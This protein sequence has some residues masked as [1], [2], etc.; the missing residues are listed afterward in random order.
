MIE[1][2]RSNILHI[3]LWIAQGLLALGFGLAGFMKSTMP[4]DQLAQNGMGFVIH[5][6]QGTVRFIGVTEL[7]AALGLILPAALRIKPILTPLA[8]IGVSVIMILAIK[9][10]LSA[11]EPIE[12][13]IIFL[14]MALFVAWG[15][16]KKIPV[17]PK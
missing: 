13:N 6:S 3:V 16:Y 12:A 7:M 1:Q 17:L 14:L 4:I 8:A 9:E 11:N 2:K 10:H 15:R 5:Y